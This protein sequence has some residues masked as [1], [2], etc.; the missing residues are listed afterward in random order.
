VGFDVVNQTVKAQLREW[1]IQTLLELADEEESLR[2]HQDVDETTTLVIPL[3]HFY[4]QIASALTPFG[5]LSQA[6]AYHEK[7]LQLLIKDGD[8]P[9]GC[10]RTHLYIGGIYSELRQLDLALEHYQHSLDYKSHLPDDHVARGQD[11]GLIGELHRRR[12]DYNKCVEYC[13][14]ALGAMR[15]ALGSNHPSCANMY[16]CL[17]KAYMAL[18]QYDIAVEYFQ[19]DL[20]IRLATRGANHLETS[21]A[22]R[23]MGRALATL[24]RFDEAESYFNKSLSIVLSTLGEVSIG[25]AEVL[26]KFGNLYMEQGMDA[27]ARQHLEK[28]RD[29]YIVLRG[30]PNPDLKKIESKISEIIARESS[31]TA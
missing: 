24:G 20:D 8:D 7:A 14:K 1:Y 28:A 15:P 19:Q 25:T 31:S 18:N 17:G 12:G 27:K 5:L 21:T 4:N 9:M 29:I 30:R 10:S 11:Y 23:N 6:L 22:M 13:Q 16:R 26:E 2:R 3:S